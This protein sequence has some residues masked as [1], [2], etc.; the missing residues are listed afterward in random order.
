M[1]NYIGDWR[2]ILHQYFTA[3][4]AFMVKTGFYVDFSFLDTIPFLN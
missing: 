1:G 4:L 2:V 3:K